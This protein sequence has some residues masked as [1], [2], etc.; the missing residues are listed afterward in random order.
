[1]STLRLASAAGLGLVL[2]A[3]ASGGGFSS[4]WKDEEWKATPLKKVYVVALRRD[5]VRRRMWE[6]GYVEGL[7]RCG[8]QATAS[9]RQYPD[10]P[11]DTQQVVQEVR[12]NQY[13]G[14]L[15]SMRMPDVEQVSQTQGYTSSRPI[16]ERDPATGSY[17]THYVQE[18]TP[19][20]SEVSTLRRFQTDVWSTSKPGGW[21]IWSAKVETVEDVNTGLVRDIASKQMMGELAKARIVPRKPK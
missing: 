14:V 1:M 6:D 7:T 21:L 17:Y 4:V 13:D 5:P 10:A 8:V 15:V 20:Q 19:G 16:V 2:G 18:T 12:A 3:C 11:P 9:Y